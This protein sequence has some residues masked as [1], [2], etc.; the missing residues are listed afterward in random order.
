MPDPAPRIPKRFQGMGIEEIRRE[1][2]VSPEEFAAE[3]AA[4]LAAAEAFAPD[5]PVVG[6]STRDT[7]VRL[8]AAHP[9]EVSGNWYGCASCRVSLGNAASYADHLTEQ[10]LAE[11]LVVPRSDI[12]G[13][14]YGWRY[15]ERAELDEPLEIPVA[16]RLDVA[17]AAVRHIQQSRELTGWTGMPA[18]ELLARP[19]LSWS[20][21]PLPEDDPK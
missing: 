3:K 15:A 14:Q 1:F 20:I 18:P 9:P 4:M 17:I 21:I 7:T 10:L 16:T 2:D 19:I 5:A 13:T 8:L 12:V 11:F 6:D